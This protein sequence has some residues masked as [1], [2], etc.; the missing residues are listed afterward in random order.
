MKPRHPGKF[1]SL[2]LRHKPETIGLT[3]DRQGW[4]DI[5]SLIA[6]MRSNGQD[7]T[8][9]GLQQ[10]VDSDAK[11]RFTISA[12]GAQIRAAQGHS[13][14]VDLGLDPSAPPPILYHGTAARTLEA[15]ARAGLIP[16]TRRQ[17]HLS[18][19][20][21]AA[22]AVGLRHGKPRV[23]V[24]DAGRMHADGHLFTQ[25]DNGVWLTDHVPTPYITGL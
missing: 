13:V 25:A 11:N 7:I 15:I 1:L 3:L 23:L 6:K 2:I 20:P 24:I 22:R 4:A 9:D 12:D 17:V 19:D 16:G 14:P 21:E 18:P 10:I 5:D 8:R